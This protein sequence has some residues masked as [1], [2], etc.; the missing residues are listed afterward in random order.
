MSPLLGTRA[1][2][3]AP[4]DLSGA[5]GNKFE[6]KL[7]YDT[8]VAMVRPTRGDRAVRRSDRK[9]N[10]VR[11][12]AETE[13][14]LDEPLQFM[15]VLWGL[16][17]TLQKASKRMGRDLGVTGPQRLVIRIVGLSPGI[18][19]GALARLLHVHP[20]T[21]TGVLQRLWKQGTIS[22]AA[23]PVDGRRAV[24]YLTRRGEEINSAMRGTVEAAVR[25]ALQGVPLREQGAVRDVLAAVS[26][27]L[28]KPLSET[29][30]AARR[31]SNAKTA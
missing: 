5:S 22:R 3:S 11:V 14:A 2:K 6:V 8:M 20:S 23:D 7:S 28:E 30:R 24:L 10:L 18:S 26:E 31:R 4:A 27:Q 15:R 29:A 13:V 12:D 16:V 25:A 1:M 9:L 17:H 19:A 21:L